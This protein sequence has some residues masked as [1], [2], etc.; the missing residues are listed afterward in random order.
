MG[1]SSL[2]VA[3]ELAEAARARYE[4]EARSQLFH[5]LVCGLKGAGKTSLLLTLPTP[6]YVFSFDP[7]GG[8][9]PEV[10]KA[11][12][13]GKVFF[14]TRFEQDSI[15]D[16]KA[17]LEFEQTYNRLGT[18][19]A[20]EHFA[21]V[22]LDSLTTYANSAL[23]QIMKKEGRMLPG[24]SGKTDDKAQGM[25]IQDWGTVLNLFIMLARSFGTLPCHTVLTAH[26][27]QEKDEV[28]GSFVNSVALP[29]QSRE[30]V[31]IN[32]SEMYVMQ[33]KP[34]PQGNKHVLLTQNDG[35]YRAS[36][37]IGG[38]TFSKEEEPNIRALMRK[39]GIPC[40]DKPALV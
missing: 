39:A 21:S 33:A 35:L 20:F 28:L 3:R 17:Y 37:R 30:Q 8:Q 23:W 31:P 40:E 15:R 34:G 27:A 11:V 18:S 13:E 36:T 6:I 22:A 19:G 38:G 25:R 26:L 32:L 12:S 16:P 10:R 4:E 24:M 7:G 14:D 9:L 1:N 29:G 2:T 5:G